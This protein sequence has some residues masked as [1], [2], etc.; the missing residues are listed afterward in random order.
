MIT[1]KVKTLNS[2]SKQSIFFQPPRGSSTFNHSSAQ[3][4]K[5]K[6]Y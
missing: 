3:N 6:N 2:R 4:Y 1:K 5:K